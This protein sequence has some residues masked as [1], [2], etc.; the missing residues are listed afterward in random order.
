[1]SII[2]QLLSPNGFLVEDESGPVLAVWAY[3]VFDCPMVL[4]DHLFTRPRTPLK[5]SLEAWR[6]AWR[7]IKGFLA[8]LR[9]CNGKPLAYKIVRIFTLPAFVKILKKEGW[10]LSENHSIQAIYAIQ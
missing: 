6:I 2:P 7:A 1:M 5:K 3:L 10:M 8:N 4:V 9:D